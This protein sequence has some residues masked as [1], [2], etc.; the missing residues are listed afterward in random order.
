MIWHVITSAR[1]DHAL[2]VQKAKT[3]YSNYPGE[4]KCQGRFSISSNRNWI[5]DIHPNLE[6]SKILKS[7]FS[8]ENA[9]H[10]CLKHC[11]LFFLV[12]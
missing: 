12:G 11:S 4:L 10:N 3:K 6:E 9:A 2:S 8:S 1:K 5:L 7:L